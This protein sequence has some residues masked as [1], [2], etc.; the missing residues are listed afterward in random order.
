MGYDFIQ[1][2]KDLSLFNIIVQLM[3]VSIIFNGVIELYSLS[4][5]GNYR[6]QTD[7]PMLYE[8]NSIIHKSSELKYKYISK[9]LSYKN[10]NIEGYFSNIFT[11]N[12][13]ITKYK[14]YDAIPLAE[15]STTRCFI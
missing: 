5:N 10:I 3:E 12:N 13:K 2:H 9:I 14:K 4:L 1:S 15:S 11:T 6:F 7:K 8:L